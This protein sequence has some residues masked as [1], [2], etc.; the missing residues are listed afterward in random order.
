MDDPW[1]S[2]VKMIS[3]LLLVLALILVSAYLVKRFFRTR[4]GRWKN[5][6]LIQVLSTTYLGPKREVSI[7]EVGNQFLVVGVT[8]YQI[9]LLSHLDESQ[10]PHFS[11]ELEKS[12]NTHV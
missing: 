6:P 12:G 4:L 2:L 3:A 7:I 11:E 1:V 9:S 10:I 8:P 5:A